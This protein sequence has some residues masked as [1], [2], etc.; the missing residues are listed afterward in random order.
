MFIR[1]IRNSDYEA[2]DNLLLQIHQVDRIFQWLYANAR[3]YTV[4]LYS[5]IPNRCR[6]R[7]SWNETGEAILPLSLA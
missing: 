2:I 5:A 3:E 4:Q 1:N 7:E 6:H